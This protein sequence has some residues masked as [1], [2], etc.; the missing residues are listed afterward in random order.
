MVDKLYNV[1]VDISFN[2]TNGVYCVKL[3]KF[4]QKKFP[5]LRPL[6]L[7]L[8]AFLKSRSL[9]ETY[10]GGIGSF[11]LTMLVTSYLQRQYKQSMNLRRMNSDEHVSTEKMDLG[12]HLIEFFNLYGQQFNFER[13]GISIRKEGSYFLKEKRGWNGRDEKTMNRL[14]VE[15]P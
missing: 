6:I 12:R 3:V 9:N 14:S 4:L 13:V 8:K 5:E 15:N 2:R 7:I 11:L 10:T 1:N